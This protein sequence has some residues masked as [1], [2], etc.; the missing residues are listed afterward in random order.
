ME[1]GR[2]EETDRDGGDNHQSVL[3]QERDTVAMTC[4]FRVCVSSNDSG[5]ELLLEIT[6]CLA[7]LALSLSLSGALL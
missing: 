7:A 2:R 3:Q 5:Y 6:V 4:V 1:R